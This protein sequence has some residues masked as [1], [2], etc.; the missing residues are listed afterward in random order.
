MGVRYS[1]QPLSPLACFERKLLLF[2][3]CQ[4]LPD[5][6]HEG[7]AGRAWLV[8]PETGYSVKEFFI[9]RPERAL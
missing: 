4:L 1:Q 8:Q 3:R 6:F 7:F 2:K 9:R 5:D